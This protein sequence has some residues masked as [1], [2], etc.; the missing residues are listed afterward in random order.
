MCVCVCVC[1]H[2][3]V[4]RKERDWE[5]GKEKGRINQIWQG[6]FDPWSQKGEAK[7]PGGRENWGPQGTKSISEVESIL[8]SGHKRGSSQHTALILKEDFDPNRYESQPQLCASQ[9][10][11]GEPWDCDFPWRMGQSG[12]GEV[13]LPRQ[14]HLLLAQLFHGNHFHV[15][16][17]QLTGL[18]WN[19]RLRTIHSRYLFS[20]TIC[21]APGQTAGSVPA[22]DFLKSAVGGFAA[23]PPKFLVKAA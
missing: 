10:A 17:K 11:A 20:K 14:H 21:W 3:F 18:K 7:G 2:V 8:T 16:I 1:M 12:T 23:L 15:H 5:R 19:C 4:H 22:S 13:H 9:V 6:L